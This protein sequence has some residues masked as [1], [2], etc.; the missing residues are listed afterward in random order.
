METGHPDDEPIDSLPSEPVTYSEARSSVLTPMGEI[1]SL[2]GFA[3]GLGARRVK[4]ALV[5]GG[6]LPLAL[7]L[8]AAIA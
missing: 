6:G 3:R 8:L 4:V 5:V 7:A 2:G 1:E